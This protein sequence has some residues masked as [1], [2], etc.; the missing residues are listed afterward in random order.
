METCYRSSLK[1]VLAQIRSAEKDS[2]EGVCSLGTEGL[3]HVVSAFAHCSDKASEAEQLIM[4]V[5]AQKAL[6]W[7]HMQF[8]C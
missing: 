7:D 8:I 2:V 3:E 6:S 1:S 4:A 5:E